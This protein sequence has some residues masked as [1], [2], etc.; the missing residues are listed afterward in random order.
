MLS[1]RG[2][3]LQMDGRGRVGGDDAEVLGAGGGDEAGEGDCGEGELHCGGVEV[4]DECVCLLVG[5]E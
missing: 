3:G 5:G 1:V 2:E 4:V